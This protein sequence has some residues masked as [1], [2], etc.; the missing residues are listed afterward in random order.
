MDSFNIGLY[1]LTALLLAAS[2][3]K[4]RAKTRAVLIRSGQAFL[5]ILP[6]FVAVMALMGTALAFLPAHV[7][8]G[9]IGEQ[10]RLDG[11]GPGLCT[12]VNRSAAGFCGFSP[13]PVLAGCWSWNLAGNSSNI[14][15]NDRQPYDPAGGIPVLWA[16]SSSPAQWH[17]FCLCFRDRPGRQPG[18][19][20]MKNQPQGY[21]LL[22]AVLVCDIAIYYLRPATGE[23]IA[24][25]TAS[26]LCNCCCA[27]PP[28]SY[29]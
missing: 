11:L 10:A 13:G 4:D 8:A 14:Y 16:T 17:V 25:Q 15:L 21:R 9:I 7:L 26:Y 24:S 22:L 18:A 27:C 20:V 19:S 6:E 3:F 12:R 5:R 1:C 29:C 2:A 23:L 28:F